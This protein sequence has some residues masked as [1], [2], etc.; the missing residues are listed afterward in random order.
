[1]VV[2]D[3][4]HRINIVLIRDKVGRFKKLKIRYCELE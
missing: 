3:K 4:I 1:M 2:G